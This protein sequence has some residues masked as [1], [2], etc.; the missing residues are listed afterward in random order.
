MV[1]VQAHDHGLWPY[2]DYAFLILSLLAVWLSAKHAHHPV[3]RWVFWAAWGLFAFGLLLEPQEL[4]LGH[5]LMYIGSFTL[6]VAH[7][8]NYLH[9][10]KP[11]RSGYRTQIETK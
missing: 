5:A 4:V 2:L 7:L 9:C 10:Q 8:K 1:G 3:L 11:T 6:V